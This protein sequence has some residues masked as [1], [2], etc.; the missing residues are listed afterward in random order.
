MTSRMSSS[1]L[2]MYSLVTSRRVPVGALTLITNWPGSVRGKKA[3]PRNGNSARLTTNAAHDD[4]DRCDRTAQRLV[5]RAIVAHQ[6]LVVL[7]V[8]AATRSVSNTDFRLLC[9]AFAVCRFDEARAEQRHHRHGDEVR[10]SQRQHHRQR[11]RGEE[12]PADAIQERRP[13]RTRWP[14]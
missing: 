8:E 14:W 6:H 1:T 4:D 5:D 12:V 9:A 10:G 3:T 2:P 13:G 11:Q 7:A